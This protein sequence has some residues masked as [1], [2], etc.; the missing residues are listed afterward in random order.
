VPDLDIEPSLLSDF[1]VAVERDAT[2][3]QYANRYLADHPEATVDVAI[4]DA[5]LEEF[6]ALAQE[7]ENLPEYFEDMELEMS[8]DLFEEN[9][10]DIR[11]GIR[12]EIVRRLDGQSAAYKVSLERD[13]QL[14]EAV[15]ILKQVDS[16]VELLRLTGELKEAQI[17]AGAAEEA[18]AA[19]T[20]EV[21]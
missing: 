12:R 3:F 17:A 21:N 20:A 11:S 18:E 10:E 2:Y 8:R 19:E 9:A 1:A 7:R 13:G 4:T 15:D 6:Y 14:W 5:M 16:R